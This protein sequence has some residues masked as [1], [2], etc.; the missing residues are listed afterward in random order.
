[1][2]LN[3]IGYKLGLAG[4][5]GI[6]LAGG[7]VAN[8]MMS[9][10][11][12]E[13]AN[14]RADRSQRVI[15]A[16]ISANLNGRQIELAA[17][18]IRLSTKAADVERNAA[19]LNRF[20][21]TETKALDDAQ[22]IATI[23][24]I[25]QRLEKIRSL[26]NSY[27]TGVDELA[28]TQL[29]L[30]AVIDKRS[31]ISAEW[32][33]AIETQLASPALAKLDN[34]LEIE[35]L[36]HM[37]DA[38]VNALRAMVWRLGATGDVSLIAQIAKTQAALKANFNLLR[39]EADDRDLLVVVSSLD[40]IVK[41]FLAANDEVVKI[42]E[43]KADIVANRTVKFAQEAGTQMDSL[44][45][46]ARKNYATSKEEA[47]AETDQASKVSLAMGIVVII[48]L[49]ASM[50]FSFLGIS[51]PMMRLNGA[52][53]EMAG[54]NLDVVI[55]GA[56][57]GDEIGDLAKT[58]TIIRENAEQKARDEAEAK[59]KQDQTAARQRKDDM[60]K[61]ADTFETAVGEIVETVSSASSEL[62]A[63]AGTLTSNAERAQE[64]TTMVAAASEEASTNVQSVASATEELSSSVN[65]I[66]RQVQESARMAT[67]AV[68]Q[69]RTTNDRVSQ[70]SKAASRIGDVVELINTIA[71]QTNLLALNA[72]IEAARAG[73][74][75]RGFAVVASEVKA[76][77]EQTSKATG[78]I[79]QQISGIQAA[80]QDSVNA[81]KEISGTIEKLSEIS[82][83]IAAA[84]EE[85]GAATQ[86]ISRN[87]QQAA[88]GT[89]QV[90]SNITD[91]QRGASETG[92]ASTQVLSAAQSLSG[93]SNR[94][95]QEVGKFLDSVRAA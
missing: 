22:A 72:T 92:S 91:V 73:D 49:F 36:L 81:I 28:K 62:E 93:D 40:S 59:I 39:G 31:A 88:H 9:E 50:V 94:L 17:R 48:A 61:L 66:S 68:D 56:R 53:G 38:K 43:L 55:P 4:A 2:K 86:E 10:Q 46:I 42:E 21:A 7:M 45:D 67:A 79:G 26:M 15:D 71:E 69:A 78:E 12:I 11:A 34:K 57:R 90:S 16:A 75:G 83:T 85:Q 1:M 18:N 58:V 5:V 52:L 80:T 70:L 87:V 82:S 29:N 77:A 54:G 41:R 14:S 13:A 65:E 51:R 74:A 35:K 8:Q 95:K 20:K 19:D 32:T 47:A 63:S 25:K 23:P 24:D 84:V 27:T 76:L 89:Q 60:I 44:V 37:A 6:L 33:K 3:R 30:L 64:L